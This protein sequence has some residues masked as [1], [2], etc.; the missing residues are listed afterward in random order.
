[1]TP[2]IPPLLPME[3]STS[4]GTMLILAPTKFLLSRMPHLNVKVALSL[5]GDS[6]RNNPAYF[7]PTSIDP[8]VSNAV[9]S[10]TSI[11]NQYH[12]DGIDIDYEH[13]NADTGTFAECIGWLISYNNSEEH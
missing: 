6:V 11:I 12:L 8:W 13:F 4:S 1:M 10:L 3:I 2:L 7:S 9:S 5:G